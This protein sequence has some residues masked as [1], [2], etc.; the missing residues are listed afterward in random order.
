MPALVHV[1]LG[2]RQL[3]TQSAAHREGLR[4]SEIRLTALA[5]EDVQALVDA[6]VEPYPARPSLRRAVAERG[7]GNPFYAEELV[8]AF[9]ER[10]DLVLADGAYDLRE[11]ATEVVPPSLHALI[12]ARIDR[13]PP[14]ARELIADTAV[15]GKCNPLAHLRALTPGEGFDEDLAQVERRGL[16][17]AEAG[18]GIAGLSFHHVLTKEVAYGIY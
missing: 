3:A 7:R 6:Q 5:A 16:L 4:V 8:R 12:A 1:T 10:G 2:S 9:R 14:S 18:G 17:D 15:L 11:G 13:L